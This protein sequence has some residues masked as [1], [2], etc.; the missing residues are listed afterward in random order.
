[1][2]VLSG[3]IPKQMMV[4]IMKDFIIKYEEDPSD[5]NFNRIAST[6]GLIIIRMTQETRQ[7]KDADITERIKTGTDLIDKINKIHKFY[8]DL[9]PKNKPN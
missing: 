6:A 7:T 5:E 3:L 2:N 8:N 9:N 4:S 1:M